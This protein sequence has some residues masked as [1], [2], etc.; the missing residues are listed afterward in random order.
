MNDFDWDV[1][2][3]KRTAS[4][5]YHLKRGSR[6]KKCTLPSDYLTARQRKGLNGEV[7]TYNLTEALGWK[8]F[9]KLPNDLKSEYMQGLVDKYDASQ[10]MASKSLFRVSD[11]TLS[12]HLKGCG[13][14]WPQTKHG[15]KRPSKECSDVFDAFCGNVAYESNDAFDGEEPME[16]KEPEVKTEPSASE[17]WTADIL[18]GR[19]TLVG[20]TPD[21]ASKLVSLLGANEKW[22]VSIEFQKE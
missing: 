6:S 1:L 5:A 21:I 16:D 18:E 19:I 2:Q 11:T 10:G 8:E 17:R 4:G 12:L 15:R 13:L 22:K 3:K 20:Y 9:K 14:V 7:E